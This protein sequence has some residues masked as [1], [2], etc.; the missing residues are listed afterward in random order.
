M[1]SEATNEAPQGGLAALVVSRGNGESPGQDKE[2]QLCD[3]LAGELTDAMAKGDRKELARII[4]N[5]RRR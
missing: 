5:I 4:K 3:A 2:Q 1:S